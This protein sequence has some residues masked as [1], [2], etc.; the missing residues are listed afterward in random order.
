MPFARSV[1][2]LGF[3]KVLGD[4]ELA[5]PGIGQMG[6]PHRTD[7]G[8]HRWCSGGRGVIHLAYLQHPH[9]GS[10]AHGSSGQGILSLVAS[11]LVFAPDA[12]PASLMGTHGFTG[13]GRPSP[14]A[15]LLEMLY[16]SVMP[17]PWVPDR[18]EAQ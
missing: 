8:Q 14:A 2:L 1:L 18:C 5:S 4:G 12:V 17:C 10:T 16:A 11:E 6:Q 3:C 15:L 13:H 7:P 9:R